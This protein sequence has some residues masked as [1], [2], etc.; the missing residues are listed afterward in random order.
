MAE[1]YQSIVQ[2]YEPLW[3]NRNDGWEGTA[4][5]EAFAFCSKQNSRMPCPYTAYCP[6][7]AGT[8]PLGGV[9]E[10]EG[11]AWAPIMNSANSWVQLGK[12]NTCELYSDIEG[13]PPA[14]GLSGEGSEAFTRNIACCLD[15]EE[16]GEEAATTPDES[17]YV[18]PEEFT[19]AEQLI[20]DGLHPLWFGRDHGY[21]GTTHDEA[22][23]FCGNIAHMDLCPIEAY[24]P[25]GEAKG[26]GPPPLF[27]QLDAFEGEQWAPFYAAGQSNL[28]VLVG[29]MYGNPTTT[30]NSYS[31]LK[32][33][34]PQW[35]LD[36][37]HTELKEHVLCCVDSS[38]TSTGVGTVSLGEAPSP[39][40]T[41]ES[42]P[43]GD[44]GE[45]L[46]LEEAIQ[47]ELKPV[48]L[49]REQGW[50]GESHDDAIDFCESLGGKELCPYAAYCPHGP[51]QPVI[52]GHTTD[53]NTEGEQ[54]APVFS[55][56]NRWVLIS[57]KKGNSATTCL[58]HKELEGSNPEW[59]LSEEKAWKKKHILCCENMQ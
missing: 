21:L 35:G 8:A 42:P 28:Y 44:D 4:Y 55:T 10:D 2:A 58:G 20:L 54:W 37:T 5:L 47:K 3:F 52:G 32:G 40:A 49:S 30:C 53:F 43:T 50:T 13:Q 39:E 41:V 14:W 27:L 16:G 34:P 6:S 12:E 23:E 59:G 17:I 26:G 18:T 11:G 22:V 15:L 57:Q 1:L 56:E 31:T 36:G 9:K 7:G 51:G 38:F 25:N 24:C 33:S 29:T 19:E 45:I 46:D 48:W